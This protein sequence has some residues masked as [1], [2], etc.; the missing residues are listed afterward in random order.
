MQSE[1]INKVLKPVVTVFLILALIVVVCSVLYKLFGNTQPEETLPEPTVMTSAESS[2]VST[3]AES[4]ASTEVVET[5]VVETTSVLYTP[6]ESDVITLLSV[7]DSDSFQKVMSMNLSD[8]FKKQH[9]TRNE[10]NFIDGTDAQSIIIVEY[11]GVDIS[12]PDSYIYIVNVKVQDEYKVYSVQLELVDN[13]I[14]S[15]VIEP[16][17]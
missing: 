4:T 1:N 14:N 15:I 6:S 9:V 3:T 17:A 13:E 11:S 2:A 8:D 7:K 5:T 12:N 10:F 16:M